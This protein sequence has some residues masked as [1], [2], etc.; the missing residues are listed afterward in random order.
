MPNA[1][2]AQRLAIALF[3]ALALVA[4]SK[5]ETTETAAENPGHASGEHGSS[6]SA[7]LPKGHIAKGEELA[8]AKGQATGQSCVDCH[9][10]E[11]N[12]PIDDTYPKLGGQ[13][14]DYLGHALQAY[15]SGDRQHALMTPQAASLS[16]QDISDLAAYFGSRPLQLRDLHGVHE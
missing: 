4:C 7:G 1:K 11:G 6:S 13:Y 9:G 12:A 14:A 8:K 3:A 15:R 5:V 2:H 16:D 10:A